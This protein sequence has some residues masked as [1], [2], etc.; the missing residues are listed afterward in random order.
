M[1]QAVRASGGPSEPRNLGCPPSTDLA[2]DIDGYSSE[3]SPIMAPARGGAIVGTHMPFEDSSPALRADGSNLPYS[4]AKDA[5]HA[6][7][8]GRDSVFHL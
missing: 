7:T 5:K 3:D 2:S 8:R 4:P 1:R 6:K